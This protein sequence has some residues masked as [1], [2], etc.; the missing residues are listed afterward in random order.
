MT[1]QLIGSWSLDVNGKGGNTPDLPS[2]EDKK[3]IEVKRGNLG[4]LNAGLH[5]L[6]QHVNDVLTQW[7]DAIGDE[8]QSKGSNNADQQEEE[9]ES[10]NDED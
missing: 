2:P 8:G 7:K 5:D 4:D 3:V 10:E 9:E 1:T 6:R